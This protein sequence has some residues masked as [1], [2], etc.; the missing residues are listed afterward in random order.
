MEGLKWL[1]LLCY[2]SYMAPLSTSLVYF[3]IFLMGAIEKAAVP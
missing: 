3:K 2:C 1:F